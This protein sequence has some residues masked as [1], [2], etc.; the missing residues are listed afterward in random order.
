MLVC[1]GVGVRWRGWRVV[2][3][4]RMGDQGVV[5]DALVLAHSACPFVDETTRERTPET[6]FTA[7]CED[8][9]R[10]FTDTTL[11]EMK[12]GLMVINQ[13]ILIKQKAYLGYPIRKNFIKISKQ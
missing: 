10:A 7:E 2:W 12:D 9:L 13:T 8:A 3:M 1:K 11:Q 6:C 5:H 4:G